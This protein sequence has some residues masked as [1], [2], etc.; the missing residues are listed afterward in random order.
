MVGVDSGNRVVDTS[1][2]EKM[3]IVVDISVLGYNEDDGDDAVVVVVVGYDYGRG[4]VDI[5]VVMMGGVSVVV[6]VGVGQN[7]S[8]G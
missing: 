7:G 6:D 3:C 4:R 5:S 8:V 2:L 1:S